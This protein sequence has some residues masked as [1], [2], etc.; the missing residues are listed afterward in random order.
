M[1]PR[2][3]FVNGGI[4]GLLT[5]AKWLRRTFTD[6][7]D[8]HAE[9]FVLTEQLS[10]PE[11]IARRVLCQR[12]W[13]D[14]RGLHNLDLARF[15]Q[16]YSAGL[17]A[18]RRLLA[19]GLDRFD[20][21]HFHRQATAYA[22]L[23]LMRQRPSIV[24]IDC[25]QRCALQSTTTA[26]ERRSLQPNIR[27]DGRIFERA[28]ALVSTSEWAARDVRRMYPDLATPIHVMHN[29]VS[30]DLFDAVWIDERRARASE[31][32]Q[33]VF[34]GGDFPRKGGY[35]LL[36]AWRQGRFAA[37]AALT[38]VTNWR[39]AGA[40]PAG[41]R[42]VTG[43]EAGSAEWID[44]WRAADLF[45]M[46]TKNEAFG[47]VYQEAAAAGLPA[48]GSRLNAVPEIIDDGRTGLL[49]TPGNIAELVSALDA[50]IR[51]AERREDLGRAARRKI[52]ID[53]SPATHRER[54]LA[55]IAQ[56]TVH[57]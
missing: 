36:E 6:D 16:E 34:M 49:V 19:R 13:P 5:Y 7:R 4:L 57:G 11:R 28:A 33:C 25:T 38:L 56:A 47:L 22:S 42:Q 14:P 12:L 15:R 26:I 20:V 10:V 21:L 35:D 45:V 41:V 9:H 39:I 8:L 51:S 3:A 52:E 32:P 1:T 53:A 46:P 31:R 40:L 29:P 2:V 37:R 30:F 55:L 17:Q 50:L 43:V 54:L 24:S 18:R 48:I 27:R 44:A 23:D